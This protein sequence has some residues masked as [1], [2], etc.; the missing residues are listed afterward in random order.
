MRLF[1]LAGLAACAAV[2][3]C[4]P[5]LQ[6]EPTPRSAAGGAA[7][8]VVSE[9]G[10]APTKPVVRTPSPSPT[11]DIILRINTVI[12]FPTRTPVPPGTPSPTIGPPPT[13]TARP[14]PTRMIFTGPPMIPTPTPRPPPT[15]TPRQT[16]D[17]A[18]MEETRIASLPP[19]VAATP[20]PDDFE[21]NDTPQTAEV[22]GIEDQID[23]LTLHHTGDV[24]VFQ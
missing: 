11:T 5:Q 22:L 17:V 8:V 23:Q 7:V 1:G 6:L 9:S 19:R 2:A 3:A 21:P 4:Q 13:G 12:A 14:S 20:E 10:R 15:R 16:V 24:D 18:E